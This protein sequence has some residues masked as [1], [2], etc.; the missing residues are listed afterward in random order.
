MEVEDFKIQVLPLQD[1]LYSFALRFLGD[2]EDAKDAVQEVFLK[3]WELRNSLDSYRSLVAFAMTVTRNHCLD[4][5][6]A[7]RT[8]PIEDNKVYSSQIVNATPG[9]IL[10]KKDLA[11]IVRKIINELPE[12]QRS[13]IQLRDI[14]GFDNQ[15]IGEIL[16]MDANNV[17]VLLS[18]ARKKVREE[19]LANYYTHGNK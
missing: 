10:E 2:S 18:R 3:L 19:L 6:K 11:E 9:D 14:D 5:I 13:V 16:K 17:R 8:I 15:E 7:K 1:K 4:R 12:N